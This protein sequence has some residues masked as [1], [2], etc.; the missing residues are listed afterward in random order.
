MNIEIQNQLLIHASKA[1]ELAAQHESS[2]VLLRV[3]LS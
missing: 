1:S 3:S 2:A